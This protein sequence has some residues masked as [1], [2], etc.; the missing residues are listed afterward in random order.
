MS[1]EEATDLRNGMTEE[2]W[3]TFKLGWGNVFP[4]GKRKLVPE[5]TEQILLNI[6]WLIGYVTASGAANADLAV[7]KLA[8]IAD[9]VG[10]IGYEW[11]DH[12]EL[13]E[14]Q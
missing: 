13:E 12:K 4:T 8:V 1:E 6:N 10:G 7:E 5:Q 3:E 14:R 9:N 2:E 11:H